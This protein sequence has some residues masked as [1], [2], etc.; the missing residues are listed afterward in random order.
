MGEM[1][2]TIIS[3]LVMVPVLTGLGR[4]EEQSRRDEGHEESR[5]QIDMLLLHLHKL[6]DGVV[7]LNACEGVSQ[8]N[9]L[10]TCRQ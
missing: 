5:T 4:G 10:I 8:M 7:V 1:K 3:E 2:V 6:I 9:E